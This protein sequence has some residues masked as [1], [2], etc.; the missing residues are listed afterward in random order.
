MALI[1]PAFR[2]NASFAN[3]ASGEPLR[4]DRPPSADF[5][6]CFCWSFTIRS[7]ARPPTNSKTTVPVVGTFLSITWPRWSSAT[8]P[9]SRYLICTRSFASTTRARGAT[10]DHPAPSPNMLCMLAASTVSTAESSPDLITTGSSP[11][12]SVTNRTPPNPSELDHAFVADRQFVFC[13]SSLRR[14]GPAVPPCCTTWVSSWASS[15]RP[16]G[17]PGRYLAASKNRFRPWVKATE[18]SLRFR[19][20]AVSPVCTR[21]PDRSVPNAVSN[22]ARTSCGSA[23]PPPAPDTARS[24][25]AGASAG[26]AAPPFARKG[27]DGSGWTGGAAAPPATRSATR[28]A[29]RSCVSPPPPTRSFG[30][31]PPVTSRCT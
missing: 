15:Q 20:V 17:V 31:T 10:L 7:N 13:Q 29:S 5:S 1:R 28:S 24:T 21:T 6:V 30:R 22:S 9:L 16:C 4:I 2:M 25:P 3:S 18:P 19:D 14:I 23:R 11:S 12:T 27:S 26:A 8:R